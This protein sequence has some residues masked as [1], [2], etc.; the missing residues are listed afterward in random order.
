MKMLISGKVLT[1]GVWSGGSGY[2]DDWLEVIWQLNFLRNIAGTLCLNLP[3]PREQ[4]PVSLHLESDNN[5]YFV[6]L[7]QDTGDDMNVRA[8]DNTTATAGMVEILGDY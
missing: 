8:Y 6:T 4:G 3:N 5:I 7:L 2:F 1:R